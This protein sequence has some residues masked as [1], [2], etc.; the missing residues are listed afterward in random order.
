LEVKELPRER[1]L[2]FELGRTLLELGDAQVLRIE[3]RL[4]TGL[5]A[6]ESLG[7]MKVN[8]LAPGGEERAIDAL[9]AQE[10]LDLA[11]L[12]ARSRLANDPQLLGSRERR[13]PGFGSTST[14]TPLGR[15]AASSDAGRG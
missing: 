11:A 8:L 6:S 3:L 2:R 14:A 13:R 9:A 5:A 10:R 4:A 1:E 15:P 12:G 7:A